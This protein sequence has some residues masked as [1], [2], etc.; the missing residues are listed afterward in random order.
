MLESEGHGGR[1]TKKRKKTKLGDCVGLIGNLSHPPFPHLDLSFQVRHGLSAVLYYTRSDSSVTASAH[2]STARAYS[3]S[4][5]N[6]A[7][8]VNV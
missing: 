2:L 1:R 3:R 5:L 4:F 6:N 8:F 7:S